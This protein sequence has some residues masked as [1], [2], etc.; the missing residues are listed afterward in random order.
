MSEFTATQIPKPSDEQAFERCNRILWSCI[1]KDETVKLYGRR[2][3]NQYGVDLT[4]IR[5][6]TPNRIVGV[7]CKLKGY[8]KNLTE[9]EVRGEVEKALA[10]RPLLSEYIVVTTAPD[11]A[12][13]DTLALE[14]SHL[15]QQGPSEESQSPGSR[16]GEPRT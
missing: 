8:G 7:Q 6:N 9:V 1:L 3:Q 16:L 4:G 2:G 15:C 10:F 12:N 14:L 11:D 13:L 5:E